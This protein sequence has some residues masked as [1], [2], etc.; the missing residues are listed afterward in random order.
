[1]AF[2][3]IPVRPNPPNNIEEP[4]ETSKIASEAEE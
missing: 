4:E 1:M 3:G 2:S